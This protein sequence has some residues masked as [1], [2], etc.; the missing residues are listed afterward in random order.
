VAFLILAVLASFLAAGQ[1]TAARA[2]E[3]A[4]RLDHLLVRPVPRR[5]WLGG[6]AVVAVAALIVGGLLAGVMAWLG[7]ASQNTAVSFAT[8]I[9]AGL[10]VIPPAICLLGIGILAFGVL[11]RATPF[12]VYGLL[13]WSLLV[14]LVGGIGGN[15]RW[16]LDTSLFHQ[17]AAAPAVHPD[18]TTNL[19]LVAIGAACAVA[20]ASSFRFRDIQGE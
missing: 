18:W 20:G 2:E 14:E 8:L 19:V 7:A 4:G 9:S 6:R 16:L 3:A 11:P 12:A 10:N 1:V 5:A 15:S 17:M 13:G